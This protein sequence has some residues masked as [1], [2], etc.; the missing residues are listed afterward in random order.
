MGCENQINKQEIKEH[1]ETGKTNKTEMV[2]VSLIVQEKFHE[3]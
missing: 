1:R 2:L 3:L